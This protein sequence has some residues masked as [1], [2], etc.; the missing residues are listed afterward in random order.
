MNHSLIAADQTTHLKI[1][2]VSLIAT[3]AVVAIGLCSRTAESAPA[4]SVAPNHAVH[5]AIAPSGV[6]ALR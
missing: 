1:V 6:T 4:A 5:A 2:T 3:I